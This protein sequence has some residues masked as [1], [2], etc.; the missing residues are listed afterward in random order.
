MD[1]TVA[2]ATYNGAK[3]L[4]EVLD[5]LQKQVGTDGIEWEVLVVDNNSN[6]N[7]AAVI[8]DYAKQWRP[9]SELRYV[10]EQ[11]QGQSY[12]RSRAVQSAKS[13]DLIG[14]LDDDNLPAENWVAEAYNFGK[15]NPKVGAYGG[16]IHAKLD[17]NAPSYFDQIKGYLTIYDRGAIPFCYKRSA[18]PRR[19]P[20]APGSVIRKQ[21]WQE[22]VPPPEKLLIKGR[23]EKTMAAGEDAEVMFYIQNSKWEVWHNPK[24]EIWHHIPS[25]RLEKTYLLKLAR[26]YGLSNHLTRVAR[27]YQW[28]RPLLNFLLPFYT[29]RDIIKVLSYY[30]QY[31]NAIQND[32]G[33]ACEFQSKIG[34]LYSPYLKVYQKL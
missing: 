6:D 34:Q 13:K 23:D 16:I 32:V 19:I 12:A 11:R 26:G 17:G 1:L 22:C 5:Q 31:R 10:F 25:H 7:T 15:E 9:D 8:S 20:A 3:R 4:P 21:A 28:Q 18:K 24:M 27:F 29:F 14:F 33:K 2:I 30:L